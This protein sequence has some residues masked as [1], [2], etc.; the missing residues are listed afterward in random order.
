MQLILRDQ[1]LENV[2]A[3][4]I[5]VPPVDNKFICSMGSTGFSALVLSLTILISIV[6]FTY[7]RTFGHIFTTTTGNTIAN[8]ST[9]LEKRIALCITGSARTFY[10]PPL[11]ERMLQNLVQPLRKDYAVDVIFNI[12]TE[13][14]TKYLIPG[15]HQ[16]G[17]RVSNRRLRETMRKFS[18]VIIHET[19]KNEEFKPKWPVHVDDSGVLRMDRPSYCTNS[20]YKKVGQFSSDCVVPFSLHRYSQCREQIVKREKEIGVWY[21]YVY[22][23]RPDMIFF[24][25]LI[26][27]KDIKNGT[28][29]TNNA[30]LHKNEIRSTSDQILIGTRNDADIALQS[31]HAVDDCNYYIDVVKGLNPESQ[32]GLWLLKHN[33]KVK[34]MPW[35]TAIVRYTMGIEC[36]VFTGKKVVNGSIVNSFDYCEGV[37][38]EEFRGKV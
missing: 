4:K 34:T 24:D 30:A 5:V 18:P 12:K 27:P 16:P 37:N 26:M 33:L 20:T 29:Y 3:I 31:I 35:F 1:Q 7:I 22:C 36:H 15:Y 21:D 19:R 14:E 8:E 10:Y 11:H 6:Y 25:H 2:E 13:K 17:Y 9:K 32:L 23:T 28:I 38:A